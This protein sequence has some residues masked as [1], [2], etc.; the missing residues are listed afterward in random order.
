VDE[1]GGLQRVIGPLGVEKALRGGPEVAEYDGHHPIGRSCGP[2]R[3]LL[4]EGGDVR[5]P[6]PLV[7]SLAHAS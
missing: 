5:V 2:F 4:E 6:D 3:G 1:L 7:F